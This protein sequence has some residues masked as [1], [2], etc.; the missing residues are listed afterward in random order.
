MNKA[1]KAFMLGVSLVPGIYGLSDV[2][3]QHVRSEYVLDHLIHHPSEIHKV[4]TNNDG[5]LSQKEID[6][7]VR[8]LYPR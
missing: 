7:F 2:I 6:N 5:V 1:V 4:D 8:S 3:G